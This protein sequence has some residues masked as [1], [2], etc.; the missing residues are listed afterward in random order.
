[1]D[2]DIS[3]DNGKRSRFLAQPGFGRASSLAARHDIAFS[4][5]PA[6]PGTDD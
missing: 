1:M 5:P 4:D 6:S 2:M 3:W